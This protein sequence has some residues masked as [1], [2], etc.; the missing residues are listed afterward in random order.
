MGDLARQLADDRTNRDAA[1]EVFDGRLSRIRQDLDERSVGG[2]IADKLT[3]DAAD[4]V[5]EAIAIA[6]QN[7]VV[8]AGTIA[9]VAI[10]VFRNPLI[11]WVEGLLGKAE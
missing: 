5:D 3:G 6:D 2:R 11:A 10:W 1:R 8:I 9:A 7:R 4:A